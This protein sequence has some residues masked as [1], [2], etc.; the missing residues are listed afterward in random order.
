VTNPIFGCRFRRKA[1]LGG[2]TSRVS[3]PVGSDPT[4][5]L[6]FHGSRQDVNKTRN[7]PMGSTVPADRSRSSSASKSS[8]REI[9]RHRIGE[10]PDTCPVEHTPA[11]GAEQSL[12]LPYRPGAV[13]DAKAAGGDGFYE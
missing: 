7:A 2:R 4:R 12:P 8:S 10:Q 9:V 1:R 3:V 5:R 13:R 6:P 11:C